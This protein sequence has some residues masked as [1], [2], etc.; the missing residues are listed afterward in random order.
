MLVFLVLWVLVGRTNSLAPQIIPS[1]QTWVDQ[2]GSPF[3]LTAPCT[4]FSDNGQLASTFQG[5]LQ[6]LTL[7]SCSTALDVLPTGLRFVLRLNTTND[8]QIGT[9]GYR[10]GITSTQV[11]ITG[12]TWKGVFYGTRTVLQML[13]TAGSQ[14][15]SPGYAV[16]WPLYPIRA[17]HIDIGRMFFTKDFIINFIKELAY[18]KCSV[19]HLHAAEWNQFRL[20]SLKYPQITSTQHYSVSD[21]QDILDVADQYYV[22]V[23][24]G[25]E[26]PGHNA[27]LLQAFPQLRAVKSNGVPDS[28]NLDLTNPQSYVVVQ[29]ILNEFL[30]QLRGP[31]FHLGTDEYITDFTLYPQFT[32]YARQTFNSSNANAQ[33]V[34]LNFINWAN[35]IVRSYNKTMWVWNDRK[36]N[37]GIFTLENNIW[38]DSWTA[39]PVA[40]SLQAGFRVINSAQTPLYPA[41]YDDY[42]PMQTQL[43]ET[44]QPNYWSTTSAGNIPRQAPGLMGAKLEWWFDENEGEQY[45]V[46]WLLR[47]YTRTVAQKTWGSPLLTPSYAQFKILSDQVGHA[48]STSFPTTLPPS[49]QFTYTSNGRLVQF[50]TANTQ[51]RNGTIVRYA[52]Q[53]GDGGTSSQANPSHQYASA[54]TYQARLIVTDSNG[55]IGANQI[56]VTTSSSSPTPPPPTTIR[57][58]VTPPPPPSPPT[59][60]PTPTPTPLWCPCVCPP[61]ESGDVA[62]LK[63]ATASTTFSST[64]A[65]SQAVDRDNSTRWCAVNGNANQWLQV[66]LQ[67]LY[68]LQHTQVTFE[69]GGVWKYLI[70]GNSQANASTFPIL[71]VNQTGNNQSSSTYID[72]ILSIPTPQVQTVRL[73]ITQQPGG[74]WASVFDFQVWT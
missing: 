64:Y 32:T 14:T 15:L 4:I 30:P 2:S 21:L 57:P 59:L 3:V 20:Q 25:I 63:P 51:A 13:K 73:L 7:I 9:E 50:N 26:T 12:N 52:W 55:M 39:N 42:E 49:V 33:D 40:S 19:L 45:S 67:N 43:Y 62:Y 70:A 23:L 69:S 24:S 11:L 17:Q 66:D 58:T 41:W 54:T 36:Q 18:L 61:S 31:F 5:D 53:F 34:Y 16:D 6:S 71:L 60:A 74:H 44:W 22:T 35:H 56:P 68:T 28:D 65:P 29:D 1:I 48:P 8:T 72:T 38:L 46:A 47:H 27:W 10:L 37:G